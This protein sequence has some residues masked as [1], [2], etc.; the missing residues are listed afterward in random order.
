[1]TD[2]PAILALMAV[3][4]YLIGSISFAVWVSQWM[5]LP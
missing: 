4:A 5:G 2:T 1:M 3:F